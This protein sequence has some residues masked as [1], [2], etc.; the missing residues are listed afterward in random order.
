MIKPALSGKDALAQKKKQQVSKRKTVDD[1]QD[2]EW[3]PIPEVTIET[4]DPFKIQCKICFGGWY[5]CAV[6]NVPFVW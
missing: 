1:T 4:D 3:L 2:K 5:I 6:D